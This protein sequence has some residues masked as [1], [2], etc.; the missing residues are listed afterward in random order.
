M[1][2][3]TG[4]WI[5]SQSE[6]A[7]VTDALKVLKVMGLFDI[8]KVNELLKKAEKFQ[9]ML[10]TWQ[11]NPLPDSALQMLDAEIEALDRA[12]QEFQQKQKQ[13]GI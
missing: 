9:Q 11:N 6:I 12:W 7:L 5:I 13:G 3:Q 2:E 1:P 8:A 10:E 4:P